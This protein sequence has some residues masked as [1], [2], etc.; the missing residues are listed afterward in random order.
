MSSPFALRFFAT[1][2]YD[3]TS[4]ISYTLTFNAL[5]IFFAVSEEHLFPCLTQL[6]VCLDRPDVSDNCVNDKS[7]LAI[8]EMNLILSILIV[9]P[10]FEFI[11]PFL[12][13]IVNFKLNNFEFAFLN[14]FRLYI[15]PFCG[16]L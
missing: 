6:N 8:K 3:S 12:I 7:F 1:F 13:V 15:L 9:I 10:P 4:I 16:T 2:N 11:L 5:A 14:N